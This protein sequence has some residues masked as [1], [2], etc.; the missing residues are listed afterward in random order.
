MN[1]AQ[2]ARVVIVCGMLEAFFVLAQS[3][4]QSRTR[5]Q[6]IKS[7][8]AIGVITLGLSAAADFVPQVA[9][10]FALLILVALAAR[11]RGELGAAL[12]VG[13]AAAPSTGGAAASTQ[14]P[15]TSGGESPGGPAR[16]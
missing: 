13:G 2:A 9:G 12:G 7:L 14:H 8:W 3:R 1:P 11:S 6:T 5:E 16:G 4:Q 15:T 10:P